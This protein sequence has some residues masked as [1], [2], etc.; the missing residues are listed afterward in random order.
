MSLQSVRTRVRPMLI[1]GAQIQDLTLQLGAAPPTRTIFA[2]LYWIAVVR[3]DAPRPATP[4]G[5]KLSAAWKI[6]SDELAKLA[7][8]NLAGD[9]VEGTFE[10]TSFGTLGKV[11]TLK[12][13]TDPAILL[14]PNFLTAAR[15]A[16]DTTDNL[17]LL[18][19]TAED[20]RF[21]PAGEK[22]LLDSIYPNWRGIVTNNKRALAKQPLLLSDGGMAGMNYSPPVMLIRPASMPTTNPMQNFINRRPSTR[23][24]AKPAGKPYIVR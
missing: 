14:S 3:W 20:V 21:M 11:G 15:K 23:P 13:K 12:Q 6:S 5:N 18:V 9:P 22:R 7:M 17:A 8:E 10:V 1:N 19:A 24:A 16:L 4:I 2:D